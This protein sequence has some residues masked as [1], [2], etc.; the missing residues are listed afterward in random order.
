MSQA[1]GS[2]NLA[3]L[4]FEEE[5]AMGRVQQLVDSL[6]AIYQMEAE[7]LHSADFREEISKAP[8]DGQH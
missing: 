4:A 3:K 8:A 7:I 1:L 5:M 6:R 2:E